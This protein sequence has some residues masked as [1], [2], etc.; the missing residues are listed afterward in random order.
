[1]NLLAQ[2]FI[3]ENNSKTSAFGAIELLEM[4]GVRISVNLSTVSLGGRSRS[5]LLLETYTKEGFLESFA[6]MQVP[7][8]DCD[9]ALRTMF[10][11]VSPQF[12]EE[13]L[14]PMVKNI[15]QA[16]GRPMPSLI[17]GVPPEHWLTN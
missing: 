3:G 1:M 5:G 14:I 8:S 12:I 9:R 16:T 17:E 4:P 11:L 13:L 10:M 6:Q 7:L 15:C 2:F